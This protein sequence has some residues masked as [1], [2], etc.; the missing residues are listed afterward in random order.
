MNKLGV[1]VN[2][3]HPSTQEVGREDQEFKVI[4]KASLRYMR[5]CVEK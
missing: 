2:P 3:G 1:V 4:L 5:L